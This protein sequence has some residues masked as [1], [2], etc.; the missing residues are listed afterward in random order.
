MFRRF[1]FGELTNEVE[2]EVK[3][4]EKVDKPDKEDKE[5]TPDKDKPAYVNNDPSSNNPSQTNSVYNVLESLD[6]FGIIR[7]VKV[8][9][10]SWPG[11]SLTEQKYMPWF[12]LRPVPFLKFDIYF[13]PQWMAILL[14]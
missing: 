11:P 13:V 1:R 12:G 5:D 3:K 7:K 9:P 8:A 10:S 4:E 6:D 2:K 14:S